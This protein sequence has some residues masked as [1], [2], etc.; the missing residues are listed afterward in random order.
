MWY[1]YWVEV[2]TLLLVCWTL[3]PVPLV[4]E[5]ELMPVTAGR[6]STVGNLVEESH[7]CSFLLKSKASC[8]DACSQVVFY[9]NRAQQ[10]V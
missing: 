8:W 9:G 2:T 1:S 10:I 7:Y 6:F 5:E 4:E 3:P